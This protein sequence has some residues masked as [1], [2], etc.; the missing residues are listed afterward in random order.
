MV[1]QLKDSPIDLT[2]GT[3]VPKLDVKPTIPVFSV[4]DE[5]I[6]QLASCIEPWY[7]VLAYWMASLSMAY[8]E[9]IV[10]LTS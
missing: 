5:K 3:S 9:L 1:K 10:D 4:I 7:L 2:P 6:D 8:C